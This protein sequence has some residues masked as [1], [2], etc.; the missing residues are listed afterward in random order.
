MPAAPVSKWGTRPGSRATADKVWNQVERI[1]GERGWY[2]GDPLWRLRGFIDRVLAGPG[3]RGRPH[4]DGTPRVGDALDFWRV[5]V[6]DEGRR[7]LLLAEMRL[8]GEALLEFKLDTKWDKAV[9]LSM[10]AKFLPRGLTGILYW[11][12]MYPFHVVLFKN[13]I[14][15]ISE[16]AGTHLYEHPQRIR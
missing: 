4:G 14:E 13:I 15:N 6:A 8:P 11:Y 1:G 16:L 10:T 12:A 9:D 2:F 5:L 7:L 3:R